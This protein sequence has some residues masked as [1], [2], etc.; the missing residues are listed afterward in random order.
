VRAPAARRHVEARH[1]PPQVL[2]QDILQWPPPR[3]PDRWHLA[4][5]NAQPPLPGT[6]QKVEVPEPVA[7]HHEP[8]LEARQPA[9]R[10]LRM[11][12]EPPEWREEDLQ[13]PGPALGII[14]EP[15]VWN[16]RPNGHRP[17]FDDGMDVMLGKFNTSLGPRHYYDARWFTPCLKL[18]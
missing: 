3:D 18:I 12:P 8:E 1:I 6:G 2:A 9:P 7:W 11:V 15:P 10:P 5:E 14:P 17:L 4:R 13:Q 16:Y